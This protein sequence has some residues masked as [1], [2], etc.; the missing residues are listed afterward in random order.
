MYTEKITAGKYYVGLRPVNF[1]YYHYFLIKV[2]FGK[3]L[4]CV[5]GTIIFSF[6]G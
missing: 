1:N 3:L 5:K 2:L 4:T 6:Y